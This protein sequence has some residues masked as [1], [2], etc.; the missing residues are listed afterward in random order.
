MVA[1]VALMVAMVAVAL[2]APIA[3]MVALM[4][5]WL[6]FAKG[7][8]RRGCEGTPDQLD[9]SLLVGWLPSGNTSPLQ[10]QHQSRSVPLSAFGPSQM[11]FVSNGKEKGG[12]GERTRRRRK[13]RKEW[14]EREGEG[15]G[16]KKRRG[17]GELIT[18]RND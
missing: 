7:A 8:T 1:L 3:L 10:G 11:W 15:E 12:T 2:G 14:T 13:G 17:S 5:G 9:P 4:V 6:R 16:E 18:C